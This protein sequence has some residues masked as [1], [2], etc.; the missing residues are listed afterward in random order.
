MNADQSKS[1]FHASTGRR[2][3]IKF[4][5]LIHIVFEC[6]QLHLLLP[7]STD[8]SFYSNAITHIGHQLEDPL[9]EVFQWIL[10]LTGALI[11]V[12]KRIIAD[13]KF[14]GK[15]NRFESFIEDNNLAPTAPKYKWGKSSMNLKW[16]CYGKQNF[17][18]PK[19]FIIKWNA[20]IGKDHPL[21]PSSDHQ[22]KSKYSEIPT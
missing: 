21:N 20:Q 16:K 22:V 2:G 5:N 19:M 6:P 14:F 1:L 13:I 10:I 12:M 7:D 9:N 3:F 4:Q 15:V 18:S 17:S 11:V 8:K